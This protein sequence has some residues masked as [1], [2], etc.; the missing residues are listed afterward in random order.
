MKQVEQGDNIR[1]HYT[2]KLEDGTVF[3]SSVDKDPLEFKVGD[4]NLIPG[5]EQGV[6]GMETGDK[7]TLTIPPEEG[8]GMARDDMFITFDKKE[9]PPEISP[10]V[11]VPL[12]LKD[13]EGNIMYATISEVAEETIT[14]DANPPLAG[15]TLVFDI[16][17]VEFV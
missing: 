10:T 7:K 15:K 13:P 8:Y 16:E 4:G 11:G 5:F 9:I 6:I 2:G 1:I 17:L 14:I 3:D 12:Q